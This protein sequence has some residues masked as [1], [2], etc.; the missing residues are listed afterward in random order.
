L[1]DAFEKLRDHVP[2]LGNDRKLSKFETLQMAQTYINA[3]RPI[4]TAAICLTQF[5]VFERS[6]QTAYGTPIAMVLVLWLAFLMISRLDYDSVPN[7][8]S[9]SIVDR[10]KQV[11][12]ITSV[13][14]VVHDSSF[15]FPVTI[16]YTSSGLYRWVI[17]LFR[18][19]IRQHA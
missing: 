2:N 6:W 10:A 15:F 9:H 11:F 12:F 5:S 1:N 18:D 17:G 16:I 19:E 7:F 4:P 13:G 14:L 3:L 8:R